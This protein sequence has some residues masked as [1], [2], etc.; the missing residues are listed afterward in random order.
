MVLRPHSRGTASLAID[1][2]ASNRHW[3]AVATPRAGKEWKN[4]EGSGSWT[5]LV[6][7]GARSGKSRYAQTRAEALPGE[8]VYVATAQPFDDEMATRIQRHRAERGERWQTLEVPL[9]LPDAIALESRPQR[10]LLI[11]CLTLWLSNLMLADRDASAEALRLGQA[12]TDATGPVIL[13]A[14]EVG[15]G[16]VPDNALARR[17]RDAAGILNQRIAGIVD[18]A[19]FLVAGLPQRLK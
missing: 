1:A 14:N 12:L 17:F 10:V 15:L 11:D 8:L 13:V 9:D 16:I 4:M 18:E 7:G 19:V 6:L 2:E 5:L 3:M